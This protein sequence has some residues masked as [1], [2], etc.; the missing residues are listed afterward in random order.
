MCDEQNPSLCRLANRNLSFLFVGVIWFGE[1]QR[2]GVQ[3][4][5][6]A[7]SEEIRCF[8]RFSA[9]FLGSHS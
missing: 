9:A 3:E 1:G 7:S 2:L 5:V 8:L 6:V 4:T